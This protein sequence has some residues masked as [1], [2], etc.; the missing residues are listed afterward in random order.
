MLK[1]RFFKTTAFIVAC[2]VLIV[3]IASFV[4]QAATDELMPEPDITLTNV[5]ARPAVQGGNSAIYFIL[6]N[7]EEDD[8]ILIGASSDAAEFV[9]IHETTHEEDEHTGH[10]VMHMHELPE[11]VV[12]GKDSLNFEPGGLHVMLINLH[13]PMRLNDR[14]QFTLQFA[15]R[16]P[17]TAEAVVQMSGD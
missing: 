6:T 8:L 4:M 9:E 16:Q 3:L 15:D 12:K 5:W 11:L 17:V 10:D 14:V 1:E 2:N 13:E 7:N